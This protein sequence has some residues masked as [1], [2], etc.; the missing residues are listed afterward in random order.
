MCY[1]VK[2]GFGGGGEEPR[3]SE[4]REETQWGKEKREWVMKKK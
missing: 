2:R 3:R 4:G 1:G